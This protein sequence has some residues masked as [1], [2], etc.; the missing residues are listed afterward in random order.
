MGYLRWPLITPVFD[1]F[2]EFGQVFR[3][4]AQRIQSERLAFDPVLIVAFVH[5]RPGKL[6]QRPLG[7]TLYQQLRLDSQQTCQASARL[8]Q[9]VA[10]AHLVATEQQDGKKVTE[11]IIL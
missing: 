2:F 10:T 9:S 5:V 6:R 7:L 4:A 11:L 8:R 1:Q 3:V